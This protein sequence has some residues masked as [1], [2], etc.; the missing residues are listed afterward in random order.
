ML[1]ESLPLTVALALSYGFDHVARQVEHSA[2][3]GWGKTTHVA[4]L[5]VDLVAFV[6]LVVPKALVILNELVA[7][8][9]NIL[10]TVAL[11]L[12]R[13]GVAFRTG[14]SGDEGE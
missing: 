3:E 10:E 12:H 9:M 7:L 13:V 14:N 8:I 2:G 11:G 6:Q 5:I 1:W 4:L